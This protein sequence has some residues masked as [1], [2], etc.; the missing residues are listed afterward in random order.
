MNSAYPVVTQAEK[1][2]HPQ[3]RLADFEDASGLIFPNMT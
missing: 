3:A 1:T 2:S